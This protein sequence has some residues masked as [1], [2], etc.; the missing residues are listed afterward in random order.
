MI[1][2]ALQNRLQRLSWDQRR[3]LNFLGTQANKYDYIFHP[4]GRSV[5]ALVATALDCHIS[6][7]YDLIASLQTEYFLLTEPHPDNYRRNRNHGYCVCLLIERE[8]LQESVA[9]AILLHPPKA[10][11]WMG[12]DPLQRALAQHLDTV[13]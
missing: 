7:A 8:V 2:E 13:I 10:D 3:T 4:D 12:F 9:Q 11:R 1:S 5:A 6:T